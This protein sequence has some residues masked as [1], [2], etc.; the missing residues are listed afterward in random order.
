MNNELLILEEL[1]KINARLEN[2]KEGQA[3]I[4]S[5]VNHLAE[6]ADECCYAIKLP[7]PKL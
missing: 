6:R 7:L 2:I 1:R 5:A 4:C 3:E